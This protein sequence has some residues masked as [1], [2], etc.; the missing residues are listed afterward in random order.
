M[1]ISL[2][3]MDL[4]E[5][6][7][8]GPISLRERLESASAESTTQTASQLR[9]M[10]RSGAG[11]FPSGSGCST[12][13]K[14]WLQGSVELYGRHLRTHGLDEEPG[15]KS[16]SLL[17]IPM[18]AWDQA[19]LVC[20]TLS[21]GSLWLNLRQRCGCFSSCYLGSTQADTPWSLVG[22]DYQATDCRMTPSFEP[23]QL[24]TAL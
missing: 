24:N 23:L 8:K 16:S 1:T 12:L 9:R 4:D 6:R 18:A 11:S 14:D 10:T 2:Q 13:H 19:L 21:L 3:S 5:I 20:L 17:G 22:P 15:L 7:S